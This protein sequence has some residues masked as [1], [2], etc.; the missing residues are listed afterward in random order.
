MTRVFLIV[1]LLSFSPH[2]TGAAEII[3]KQTAEVSDTVIHLGDIA[4]F[5]EETGLTVALASQII[6][7]APSPGE[8]IVLRSLTLKQNLLA[9]KNV[10]E[11]TTW[12]GSPSI[13]VTRKGITVGPERIQAIIA[14]YLL[15]QKKNL[16]EA[17]VRFI[18]SSLP[19]PFV[20]PTGE[21]SYEVIPS[22]PAI[23]GS[24]RFSIIFRVDNDV[25][26]N[27]S[28]RGQIE[29]IANVVVTAQA[30][31]RGTILKPQ[32]L[33]MAPM[34]ISDLNNPQFEP[35]D[36]LEMKLTKSLRAG[37]PVLAGM[38]ESLPVVRRGEKVKIV[39]NSGALH[40]SATGFAFTDGRL[41]E[42]IRV[43]NISSNKLVYCRVAAPGLVE[44]IL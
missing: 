17:E 16:P 8:A 28:V 18:P 24:S 35:A 6:G 20:L 22:N 13:T 2:T 40:V 14:E 27:M 33:T 31:K 3:F 41:D 32:D 4:S 10:P 15:G 12:S 9:G 21:L 38:V 42:M 11:E 26:K 23:L 44:V 1:L 19:L 7:Q 34:D 29:A 25:A 39:I 5:N 30:L 36:L 43:Q 37:T